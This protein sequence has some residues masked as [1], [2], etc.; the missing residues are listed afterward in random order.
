MFVTRN[1]N[2]ILFD[3]IIQNTSSEKGNC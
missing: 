3:L 2:R 1:V